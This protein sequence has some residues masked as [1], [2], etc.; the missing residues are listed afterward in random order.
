MVSEQ[1]L[2]EMEAIVRSG[3]PLFPEDMLRLIAEVRRL[4]ALLDSMHY[5]RLYDR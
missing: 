3:C 2:A 5:D 1:E 4:E